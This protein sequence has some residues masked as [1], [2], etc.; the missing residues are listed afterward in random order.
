MSQKKYEDKAQEEAKETMQDAQQQVAQDTPVEEAEVE[1]TEEDNAEAQI[2]ELKAALEHEKKEYLFLMAEFDNFRKRKARETTELIKDANGKA[3]R[4]LLP[5]VDD[6]ERALEATKD[7]TDAQAV[8]EGMELIYNKLV[9]LME[10][11]GVKAMETQDQPFDPE[12]H[13]AVAQVP[14]PSEEKKDHIIDTVQKGYT[15]NDKVMRH[16]KVVVAK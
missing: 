9:K 5:I 12:L 7:S 14:A 16:A 8:R 3:M 2:E 6:F 4:D 11:K 13:E 10:S 15:L 1:V